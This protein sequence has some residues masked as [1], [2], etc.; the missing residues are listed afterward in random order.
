MVCSED[1][2]KI[3]GTGEPLQVLRKLSA[4]PLSFLYSSDGIRRIAWHGTELVRALAWPIRDENWGTYP[5]EIQK[6]VIDESDGCTVDLTFSVGDGRMVCEVHIKV[7]PT[8]AL[9]ADL[10]MTPKDGA[11]ATNRAGFTVLHPIRGVAGAKLKV[12]HSD[13]AEEQ[14]A[15]PELIRPDQP[16]K[17]IAGLTY[18]IDG[19]LVDIVFDGETFEM[20]D[21]RNWSDASFKTYCVPLVHPFTYDITGP[22]RQSVRMSFSG[23]A[24]TSDDTFGN[25]M[26]ELVP[27]GA[28]S[29]KI[30]LALESGWLPLRE[31]TAP[32]EAN[33]VLMRVFQDAAD[34]DEMAAFA[35]GYPT[36]D[37]EV[38]VPDNAD[39]EDSLQRVAKRVATE[40]ITPAHVIALRESY[41]ASHQPVGP[42]PEGATPNDMLD[43]VRAAFPKSKVGGGM[44]TNFTELNRCRPD[45]SRCDYVTHSLT[46]LVHAG[47]DM[48]VLETLETLP[49]IFLSAEALSNGRPYRLGL[50]SIGMRSNP[51]G[52]AVAENPNQVRRTM[53][54]IDPRHRGLF[55]AAYSVGV[56]AATAGS[57]VEAICLGSPAGPFGLTYEPADCPQEGFDGAGR[58]VYPI[59]HVVKAAGAM[60]GHA[61]LVFNGVPD[62]LAA[63]GAMIGS[64]KRAMIANLSG[65]AREVSISGQAV[66]VRLDTETFDAATKSADWLDN[67]SKS[68]STTVKLPPFAVAFVE[69]DHADG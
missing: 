57:N 25:S 47:D 36:V 46:P 66:S 26:L 52:A 12:T 51:Y 43:L 6:E 61:R 45:M 10:T 5:E 33:Y 24:A 27:S 2:L 64:T 21:Q 29:P 31:T 11:F 59:Y 58:S 65:E 39:V 13:G 50:A 40:R 69:I 30:G 23:D 42:W 7:K 15:F 67:A 9:E 20:E 28:L 54:R 49:Q 60:A 38:V 14:T 3:Y 4:G 34:L 41:L 53:A 19:Q 48:S 56:L 63:Y 18:G 8:G 55:G 62:G 68:E 35:R 17:D 44:M 22:T 32:P 1:K 37:L 16:V